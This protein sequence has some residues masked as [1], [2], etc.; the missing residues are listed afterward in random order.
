[1]LMLISSVCFL[2]GCE[3]NGPRADDPT[4]PK[5][6]LVQVDSDPVVIDYGKERMV[7]T[8]QSARVAFKNVSAQ[9]VQWLNV[10]TSCGCTSAKWSQDVVQPGETVMLEADVDPPEIGTPKLITVQTLY[11]CGDVEDELIVPITVKYDIDWAVEDFSLHVRGTVGEMGSGEFVVVT[12]P[13]QEAPKLRLRDSGSIQL[14]GEPRRKN[15]DARRWIYTLSAPV[16]ELG[17]IAIGDIAIL[18]EDGSFPGEYVKQVLTEG[19]S[20]GTWSEKILVNRLESPFRATI[21]CDAGWTV[22]EFKSSDDRIEIQS[23]NAIDD[24]TYEVELRVRDKIQGMFTVDANLEKE[25]RN[26]VSSL[27]ILFA[28]N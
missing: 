8:R 3:S 18:N 28:G 4:Q 24:N 2:S 12:K 23:T 1:M 26:A 19:K 21:V 27:K 25:G 13:F 9:S 7:N 10:S 6:V 15:E 22:R 20:P 11:R 17:V 14:V 16:S 5:V